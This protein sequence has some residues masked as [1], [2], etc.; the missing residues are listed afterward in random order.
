MKRTTIFST[1]LLCFALSIYAEESTEL[2]GD[3]IGTVNCVDYDNNNAMTTTINTAAN[4]FDNNFNTFF[5]TYQR[6]GGWAGLDLGEKH[7]IT[8]IAY[9]PR[10]NQESRLLLGVFEG[11]NNPDFGDAIPLLLITGNTPYNKM[12]EAEIDC[13]RGFRYVRYIGPSDVRCNIAELKFYG[14]KGEGDDSKLPEITNIPTVVI[15][16]VNAEDIVVKEKYLKGIVSVISEGGTKIYTDSL[17]VRGRGNAS[18]GFEKK[19]YRMKLYNKASLLGLPAKEKN[20]TLINNYGDKTL[21]RNFLAFDLS[22]RFELA[23]TPAGTPVNVFLNGD[24]KGCYQLCDHMEVKPE[25]I[26]VDEMK[27]GDVQLPELSGGYLI[28]IDA[29][30]YSEISWFMSAMKRTPVTVKY[31]A[32]DEIVPAQYDYI[33]G[34]FN[35]LEVAVHSYNFTDPQNGY[36]KYLDTESF[37]RHFL[38]GEISGNTDTYW[39]TYMYKKRNDDMFYTGPVWDFDIAFE[40]DYRTYPI[41]NL[42]DWIFKTKG[43]YADGMR[44]FMVRLLSDPSFSAEVKS[45]YA[46]YRN[47]G[48]ISVDSL[49]EVIDDYASILDQSQ[50][51]NFTRWDIMYRNVHMNPRVY[52]SYSAEVENVRS[53]IRKRIKKVDT[54]LGYVPTSNEQ[55]NKSEIN[56]WNDGNSICVNGISGDAK[57]YIYDRI[58]RIIFAGNARHSFE[59]SFKKGFYIVKII[60]SNN[61][62]KASKVVLPE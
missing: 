55:A 36:R 41:D 53:Y 37:I 28:E 44:D 59:K 16:T 45:I 34:H 46:S 3:I 17:D 54:M 29:Y 32:D 12:T 15:H 25:R 8:T 30:A 2:S 51:L 24:F 48:V 35:K 10:A 14:Y 58:G 1:F 20:W 23:Y 39:S 62:A 42:N 33:K 7:I 57:V 43:S 13:S 21:M 38:V 18:W 47:S 26:E 19:P 60:D 50:K 40:N 9:C 49:L 22:R 11:A 31:P 52:G 56:I 6:S 61:V 5:A 27:A 4:L